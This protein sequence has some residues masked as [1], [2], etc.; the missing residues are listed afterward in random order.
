MR[1]FFHEWRQRILRYFE[2]QIRKQAFLF[3]LWKW[4]E[5]QIFHEELNKFSD[6]KEEFI[7]A[8]KFILID[9]RCESSPDF[10][11]FHQNLH[12]EKSTPDNLLKYSNEKDSDVQQIFL[13]S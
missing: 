6:I 12:L 5:I 7:Q 3:T 10:Y 8:W 13:G 4:L 2:I 9:L 11:L 1:G